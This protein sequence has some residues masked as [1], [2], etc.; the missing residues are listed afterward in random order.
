MKGKIMRRADPSD[1]YAGNILIRGLGPIMPPLEAAAYLTWRPAMPIGVGEIERH[2]RIHH[3]MAVCD[4]HVPSPMEIRLLT[5]TD[6]LVRRAY[7]YRDP[8]LPS[9]WGVLSGEA[10]RRGQIIVSGSAAVVEGI[11]GTGKT[12]GCL[13]CINCYPSPIIEHLTFPGLNGGLVQV[14]SLSVEVPPS[15]RAADFARALMEAWHRATGSTRFAHWL[16]K[17]RIVDG[18]KALDEWLQV[19]RSHFLGILHLDEIQNLFKLSS[20]RQRRDRKGASSAPDLSIVEDQVLRWI[21]KLTSGLIPVL[22]SGTPDGIGALS[23]RLSTLERINMMGYHPFEP[24]DDPA[25]PAFLD[26]FLGELGKYQYVK[27]PIAIDKQLA[28]LIVNLT[29]G[30]QRIIIA[31]WIAAHRVAFDR[32][33]SDDLRLEDFVVAASTWLAPLAPAVAALRAKD[34]EK[35]AKYEDLI[36]RDTTFWASFWGNVR[37]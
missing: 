37:A 3:L 24:F 18:M 13:R 10:P 19:A 29:G 15:G 33:K 25:D 12:Q 27:R 14:V 28:D 4:L 7:G 34:S 20:L 32:T 11:S 6:L 1:P 26:I 36:K 23:K 30:V 2:I 8:S 21:L 22:I 17:D 31:L 9:T 35:M 16:T 5:T